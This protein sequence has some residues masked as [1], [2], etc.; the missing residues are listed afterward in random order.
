MND[1]GNSQGLADYHHIHGW[2]DWRTLLASF[3]DPIS[4]PTINGG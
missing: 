2:D 1:E 3:M 4:F